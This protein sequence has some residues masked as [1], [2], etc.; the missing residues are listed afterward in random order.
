MRK[1]LMLLILF[2][3][4]LL[5]AQ[6]KRVMGK[7]VDTGGFP[8]P[9]VSIV[10]KGTTTGTVTDVNGE[11]YLDNVASDAT[12]VFSFIGFENMNVPVDG[13]TAINV[14]LEES[15]IG[16]DEVVAVGYGTVKKAN[17]VGSIAKINEDALA[18]RP[19]ARVEQALQGQ[20]AGVSVRS[21]SGA[22]GSDIT[23][24]VRGAASINGE[25]T[26]LYVVDGVP[27]DNLSGVNPSDISSIEVLKD[28]ASAA[29]YGSRG[30]NGVIL[31]TT[32][33]GKT[34][35]P[36]ITLSAYTALST[37][38]KKVDVMSADEW[39]DFNKK[40]YDRQWVNKTGLSASV[41]QA[42][43]IAYAEAADGKVYATRD[44]L[45]AIRSTYGIYDPYWDT[46]AIEAIDWQ[47][48]IF[49]TAPSNDIQL[50]ASGATDI[51]NYSISG[52]VFQQDGIIE[53]SSFDRYTMRGN[54]EA[55]L[56]K[57]ITI[58]LSLAPSFGKTVGASVD[59]KDNA[60]SKALSLTP[61]VLAGSGK[62]AGAD[63]YKFYDL[64]GAG[65]NNVS[66]YVM[67]VYNDRQREDVR[68]N[69]SMNATVNVVNGLNVNGLVSW[70]YRS[71]SDRSYTPTWISSTWN[72]AAYPG[73]KSSSR[74]QT[75]RSHTVL[76]QATINYDKE[77]G[78]HSVNALAGLSQETYRQETTDQG[79]GVLA[80]DKTWVFTKTSGTT[81]NYNTLAA[82][83]N[84]MISYFGRMQ[85]G[86]MNRYLLA[87]S[88]RRDG[89]SKFGQN[90]RWGWFPSVSAAWK[91]NEEGFMQEIDWVGTAK[92]RVSWG[93]AGNDRIGTGQYL[94]NMSALNYP[95]GDSQTSSNGFV[96]G[97]ISNSMLGWEKTDSYNIGLDFG[98]WR[99]RVYMTADFYYKKT[100]DLLLKAPV[101]LTTGFSS[102]MDNVGSVENKGFEVEINSVNLN[103]AFKWNTSANISINR[104]E[105]LSLGDD[106]AD[107]L[108]GQGSTI[109]QRVGN[110]IN[111]YYLLEANGVLRESDFG[112][113]N[114]TTKKWVDPKVPIYSGQQPGDTKYVD[115]RGGAGGA[116]DG[117][118]TS[119]D[120]D[121]VGAYQPDFEWGMTNTFSYKDFDLSILLQGRVGGE[122]LS[123]GSRSWNKPTN[124]P[125]YNYMA[126]W[127]NDAYWSEED[128][129][130]GSVPAFYATVTGAQYDTNWLYDASYVRIKNI[131]F[132]YTLPIKK[133]ILKMARLYVSCDNVYM[134]DNYY[135]GFSPEAATQDNGSSDWGSYPLA[136]TFSL[137]LN[138]TF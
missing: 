75:L 70:N 5:F 35:K 134:W 21:T 81:I 136:R 74:Y 82:S 49:R 108:S 120:Y 51:L 2:L 3:P 23:V 121:A 128:P 68:M 34:G 135:P 126:S 52:G 133:E 76:T 79:M 36:V 40:F 138:V 55:K 114:A 24:N 66:P 131:T 29:I 83:E 123:I 64:W 116:K 12:L 87:A 106:D 97:N 47:D 65:A 88:L 31:V 22:P 105:I 122:L 15:S 11:F 39:L 99:N 61:W 94:S 20:M 102:M 115:K 77:F 90:N 18:D 89:S 113:Y 46:D 117:A 104:N 112:S 27:L 1:C 48:A 91:M 45:G 10:L 7:V 92:L 109:I 59:G 16:L 60:V 95:I 103:G 37:V 111:S 32:K 54:M 53:G 43:R 26:P 118:I 62:M 124:A 19:V 42:D 38:E 57:R 107:I 13:R 63:P 28:A 80:N 85:Y 96:V 17:V 25:S 101:S 127:L 8:L 78:N 67:A 30:S 33:K 56:N 119:A 137:G 132:G 6:G 9:G 4:A 86:F 69:S 71:N 58:G 73:E 110:P 129:G 44:A 125:A 100:T 130:N 72:T 50:S 84:A 41:S 14:I 93:Q 98:L